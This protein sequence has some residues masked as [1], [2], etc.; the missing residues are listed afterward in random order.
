ML[1]AGAS[2]FRRFLDGSVGLILSFVAPSSSEPIAHSELRLSNYQSPNSIINRPVIIEL[3]D[4][5]QPTPRLLDRQQVLV[6]AAGVHDKSINATAFDT[7]RAVERAQRTGAKSVT[8]MLKFVPANWTASNFGGLRVR[9]DTSAAVE[10]TRNENTVQEL[11]AH[12]FTYVKGTE[13]PAASQSQEKASGISRRRTRRSADPIDIDGTFGQFLTASTSHRFHRGKRQQ[14][15]SRAPIGGRSVNA[16]VNVNGGQGA[17]GRQCGRRYMYVNFTALGLEQYI[18]APEGY[19]AWFCKGSC[20]HPLDSH[21]NPTTHATLQALVHNMHPGLVP[22]PCCSPTSL[23]GLTM[24]VRDEDGT[25]TVKGY[26]DMVV[27]AC[28]CR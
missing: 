20:D 16:A 12:L 3:Y 23:S 6:D 26:K 18:A 9:R 15:R 14:L 21:L 2:K 19:V 5:T 24:L 11:G 17:G 4:V 7:S 22:A 28:G 10:A 27:D 1:N 25:F 13:R 8:V